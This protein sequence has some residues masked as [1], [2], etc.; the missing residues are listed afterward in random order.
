MSTDDW[1]VVAWLAGLTVWTPIW[2]VL[3]LRQLRRGLRSAAA[4]ASQSMIN[5]INNAIYAHSAAPLDEA[6]PGSTP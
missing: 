3:S 6:H 2:A 4:S 5:T 1:A